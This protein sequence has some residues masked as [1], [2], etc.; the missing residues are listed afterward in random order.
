MCPP[1]WRRPLK[2]YTNKSRGMYESH[3]ES[4][5]SPPFTIKS[6][7]VV[8]NVETNQMQVRDKTARLM[9]IRFQSAFKVENVLSKVHFQAEKLS[10]KCSQV[11]EQ[12]L[13]GS[14]GT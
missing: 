6:R 10:L 11:L 1:P 5:P 12:Y 9:L 14:T 13:H 7:E 3:S 4:A 2:N 8:Q